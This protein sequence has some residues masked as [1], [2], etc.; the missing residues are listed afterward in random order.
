[1]NEILERLNNIEQMLM[2]SADRLMSF[3]EACAYA[4]LSASQMYKLTH[5]CE[6][7]HYKP[8]GK[9]IYFSK[10]EIDAWL[11]RRRIKSCDEVET[12]AIKR[13]GLRK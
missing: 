1:M 7:A 4:D 11:K 9:K 6:I 10:L 5:Q 8:N 2:Q 12:E 3:K 13:V